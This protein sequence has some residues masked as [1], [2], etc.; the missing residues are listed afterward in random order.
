MGPFFYTVIEVQLMANGSFGLLYNNYTEE[1]DAEAD[2]YTR[3]AAAAKSTIPY[4]SAC[5]RRSDGVVTE[6][7]VYDRRKQED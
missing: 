1:C 7:R 4:H 5:I 3:L 6:G 2:L